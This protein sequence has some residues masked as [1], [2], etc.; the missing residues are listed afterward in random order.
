MG[1]T[2]ILAGTKLW[3]IRI[4]PG[5]INAIKAE[6]ESRHMSANTLCSSILATEA[7]KW[8]PVTQPDKPPLPLN[9]QGFKVGDMII[10]KDKPNDIFR[11]MG[12]GDSIWLLESKGIESQA[13]KVDWRW[14]LAPTIT[15]IEQKQSDL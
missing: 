10:R 13:M 11:I 12:E 8:K 3:P 7:M 1:R 5:L 9:P 2:R 4:M 6:A 14:I 15:L